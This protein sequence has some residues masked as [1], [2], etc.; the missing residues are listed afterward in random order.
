[1]ITPLATATGGALNNLTSEWPDMSWAARAYLLI[2]NLFVE[3]QEWAAW[4]FYD[5]DSLT[6]VWDRN[7]RAPTHLS[8]FIIIPQAWSM[9]L[10]LMFYALAP[11]SR[12]Y[13]LPRPSG[14]HRSDLCCPRAAATAWV[15]RIGI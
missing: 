13:T 15:Q 11:F 7:G 1:L 2:A 5:H 8:P 12:P 6:W 10:E 3:G 14:V 4:L 9:S